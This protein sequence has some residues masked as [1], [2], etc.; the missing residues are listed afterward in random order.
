MLGMKAINQTGMNY[1]KRGPLPWRHFERL[2][3]DT[4]EVQPCGPHSLWPGNT[5]TNTS[6][7]RHARTHNTLMSVWEQ[8][9]DRSL[10]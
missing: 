5:R 7:Q 4:C 3:R 9:A 8:E 1:Q 2:H 6:A 10:M